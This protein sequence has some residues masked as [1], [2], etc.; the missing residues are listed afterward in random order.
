MTIE[1]SQ[2]TNDIKSG[3][4][5]AVMK[6]TNN[7]VNNGIQ[8]ARPEPTGKRDTLGTLKKAV[9]GG[10][11]DRVEL[12]VSQERIDRLTSTIAALETSNSEKIDSLKN[13]IADGTYAVSGHAVAEK[14][15]RSLGIVNDGD[16]T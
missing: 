14:M 5:G 1:Q 6:V 11:S 12:S 13:Q 16:E 9:R 3:S 7:S 8:G 2:K 10:R 15:L 4:A